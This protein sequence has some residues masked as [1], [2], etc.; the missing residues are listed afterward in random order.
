VK[1]QVV[2]FK[3]AL[4]AAGAVVV[5]SVLSEILVLDYPKG[6]LQSLIAMPWPFD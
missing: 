6:L 5:L 2:W 1:A 3:A 4:G